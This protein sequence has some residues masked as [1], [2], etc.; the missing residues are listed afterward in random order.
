MSSLDNPLLKNEKFELSSVLYTTE[1]TCEPV[2][3]PQKIKNVSQINDELAIT[4]ELLKTLSEKTENSDIALKIEFREYRYNI[5]TQI[6]TTISGLPEQDDNLV[7]HFNVPTI[8]KELEHYLLVSVIEAGKFLTKKIYEKEREVLPEKDE[9]KE[10]FQMLKD[11]TLGE[12]EA[13]TLNENTLKFIMQATI[14]FV[15]NNI[16][17]SIAPSMNNKE[18]LLAIKNQLKHLD[19]NLK[20]HDKNHKPKY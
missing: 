6:L 13:C 2:E 14:K 18:A 4:L 9:I 8:G 16:Q 19:E 17:E 1:K 20:S 7:S 5:S 3:F 10:L 11:N 12:R 15:T